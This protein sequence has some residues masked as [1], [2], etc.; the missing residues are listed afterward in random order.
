MPGIENNKRNRFVEHSLISG[1]PYLFN[2][3]AINSVP[4]QSD[5]SLG[6]LANNISAM[7]ECKHIN[8]HIHTIS[9]IM[10]NNILEKASEARES[11]LD[12]LIL[13][14][15]ACNLTLSSLSISGPSG[16]LEDGD[17]LSRAYDKFGEII[18][19][20]KNLRFL[21][22]DRV[23]P[24]T[25]SK[26][27]WQ[28][29]NITHIYLD[30]CSLSLLDNSPSFQLK[31]LQVTWYTD[32]PR[33]T[34]HWASPSLWHSIEELTLKCEPDQDIREN[35]IQVKH[36]TNISL[37]SIQSNYDYLIFRFNML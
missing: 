19:S 10:R 32:L 36:L 12:S 18:A 22:F 27:V 5:T 8:R 30:S 3:V 15:L 20:A 25:W 24:S 28:A 26:E 16:I 2:N 1:L 23:E 11:F 35:L 6:E 7:S 31:V 29:Y 14:L 33:P 37:E 34:I 13:L 4:L 9:I 21:Y 17:T